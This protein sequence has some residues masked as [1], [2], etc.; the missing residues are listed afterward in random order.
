MHNVG[1]L[2]R[3]ADG[4]GFTKIY[5][6]GITPTPTDRFKNIRQDFSKVSLGAERSVAWE[7]IEDVAE[8][9]RMLKKDGW[10]IFALEQSERSV[11]LMPLDTRI[12]QYA[13]GQR[14]ALIVGNEIGGISRDVL[15]LADVVVDIPMLGSKESLNVAVAFGIAA[16]VLAAALDSFGMSSKKNSGSGNRR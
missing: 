10:T 11:P 6:C 9:V 12:L 16:Y 1:S 2:F 14:V 8:L 4:A 5:L 13:G 7:Y 3:T 15:D